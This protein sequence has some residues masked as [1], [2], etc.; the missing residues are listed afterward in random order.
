MINTGTQLL[1]H[2]NAAEQNIAFITRLAD[3]L[4]WK[5]Q[6]RVD[7]WA[8]W[9]DGWKYRDVEEAFVRLEHLSI[10]VNVVRGMVTSDVL[11]LK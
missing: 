11:A 1:D 2:I 10:Y 7:W 9:V 4:P 3:T 6:R 5:T 8:R